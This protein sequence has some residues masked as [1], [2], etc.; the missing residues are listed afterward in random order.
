M[1]AMTGTTKDPPPPA[2]K[3]PR[4]IRNPYE[5]KTSS[6]PP[7]SNQPLYGLSNS[8]PAAPSVSSET[9]KLDTASLHAVDRTATAVTTN[10]ALMSTS[11]AGIPSSQSENTA[12]SS[13]N[14]SMTYSG[15]M[16]ISLQPWQRL[17][18]QNL[19]FGSAEILSVTECVQHAKLYHSHGR[20]IRCTGIIQQVVT[21]PTTDK[22]QNSPCLSV[23][24]SDPLCHHHHLNTTDKAASLWVVF[25][26]P[27]QTAVI[28]TTGVGC[29][30][31]V[32]GEPFEYSSPPCWALRVRFCL[33]VASTTNLALQWEAL[34]L[35]RR[36]L[37]S[38]TRST[39]VEVQRNM[40]RPGCGPPPYTNT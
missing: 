3:K 20:S 34:L 21:H 17:P 4:I 1:E 40:P 19:S 11:N 22:I 35:R 39:K 32:L 6:A 30:V 26:T 2:A 24:L 12:N 5:K 7:I 9:T 31:T 18:S 29:P 27:E 23:R 13:E 38:T 33:S 14:P 36:H 8:I 37:Q 10:S 15:P 16:S 25:M 28:R